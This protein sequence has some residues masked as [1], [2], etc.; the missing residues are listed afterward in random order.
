VLVGVQR[1]QLTEIRRQ[2]GNAH[3]HKSGRGA[4]AELF[5]YARL[6]IPLYIARIK[7]QPT[8]SRNER[9]KERFS[10]LTEEAKYRQLV[11]ELVPAADV[12]AVFAEVANELSKA[13][14]VVERMSPPAAERLVVALD[15]AKEKIA[16]K[17]NVHSN[18]HAAAADRSAGG[19]PHRAKQAP[20]RKV[21]K[22]VR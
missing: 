10:A 16:S 8:K 7:R 21:A 17:F 18:G 11:R 14:G 4:A 5:V 6:W 12:A 20:A 19:K 9:R 15:S 22:A 2:L 3:E 1:A 13:I